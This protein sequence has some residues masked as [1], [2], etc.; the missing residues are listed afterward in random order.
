MNGI[1]K[2]SRLTK[3]SRSLPSA[4]LAALLMLQLLLI[5]SVQAQV[6]TDQALSVSAASYRRGALAAEAIVTAFGLNLATGV[7]AASSLPLP[8]TL[9]GTNVKVRDGAGAERLAPLFF[10]SPTQVNYQMPAGTAPGQA[11]I[12]I[13]NAN[14]AISADAVEIAPVAPGLFSADARG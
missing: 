3:L 10:V 14:G 7:M 6:K 5:A 13:T 11:I 9:A 2:T 8:T 1:T 4:G 12:T